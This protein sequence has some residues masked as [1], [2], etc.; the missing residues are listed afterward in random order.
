MKLHTFPIPITDKEHFV[1]AM[2][3]INTDHLSH[4]LTEED[5]IIID[6]STPDLPD[7]P[8]HPNH[9]KKHSNNYR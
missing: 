7:L 2:E 6:L 4:T 5:M 9:D 8:L 1:H 3:V